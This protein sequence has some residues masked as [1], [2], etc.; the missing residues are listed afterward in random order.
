MKMKLKYFLPAAMLATA[1]SSQAVPA[2]PGLM[3]R[4]LEDGS[5]VMVRLNGDEFFHYLT[6]EQGF[7]LENTGRNLVAYK[8]DNGLRMKATPEVLEAMQAQ[9]ELTEPV[10]MMRAAEMQRLAALDRNGRTTFCTTGDVNFLVVLVQFDDIKFRHSDIQTQMDRMLNQEGY[11]DN[12]CVGSVRDYFM[13]SSNGKF[14]PHFDITPVYTLSHTS[15]Y[16]VGDNKYDRIAEL[17]EEAVRLADSD[18]DFSKY[19]YMKDGECDNVIIWYAG[20]GQADTQKSD[21]IWP[22]QSGIGYKNVV[23]DNTK[24]TSYCCFNELNGGSHYINDDGAMAGIGTPIHEFNHVMGAPDLY[25][26]DYRVKSTPGRWSNLDTGPYLGDGYCPPTSSAYERYLFN[27]I[28]LENVQDNTHYDL[29][30][31]SASGRAL[32]IP[33]LNE[34]GQAYANEYF[35]LESRNQTGFDK[36][37]PGAGMLI[38]HIDYNA[39]TWNNNSVNSTESRKR[40]HLITADGSANYNLGNKNVASANAAWP[41]DKNNYLTPDT[42]ITL[43]T[44]YLFASSDT[45]NS[46]ITD[47]KFDKETGVASFDYNVYTE[48]PALATVLSTPTRGL[49]HNENPTNDITLTWEPVEGATAYQLTV[50]R[51]SGNK[52]YYEDNLDEKNVGNVTSYTIQSMSRNKLGLEFTAWVRVVKGIPSSEKSNE[53]VFVPN[54]LEAVTGIDGI[55]NDAQFTVLGGKGVIYA[56]ADAEIYNMQGV[57]CPSEGLAPG[58]YIVRYGRNVAKALVK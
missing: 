19:T 40:C 48:T 31:L 58:M 22:H 5:K 55:E 17:V 53:I 26:P 34:Q 37:L 44:N 29:A 49:D 15:G 24:I 41:Y 1:L 4:T 38:W 3:E 54:D 14:R 39:T 23:L 18:V 50:C 6:D 10:R 28:E 33:V 46:F 30:E 36:Y 35:V 20:Y 56:P 21:A 52:L 42:D 12:G 45:G 11:T 9:M 7:I 57:R 13:T 43:D 16:Y 2:W 27:W 25:D 51:K 8:L 47:I 32:R